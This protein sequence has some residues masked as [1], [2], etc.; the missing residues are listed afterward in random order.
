VINTTVD[1]G[2]SVS[3]GASVAVLASVA[4]A[5]AVGELVCV[6]VGR[7]TAVCVSPIISA[8]RASGSVICSERGAEDERAPLSDEINV[9]V[10][11]Q[12]ARVPKPT[13]N[14]PISF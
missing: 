8:V 13:T 3:V 14:A 1:V 9:L 4:D 7:E 6:I 11:Q 2:A 10:I 5:D 12:A